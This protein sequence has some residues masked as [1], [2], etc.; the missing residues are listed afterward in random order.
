MAKD[1]TKLFNELKEELKKEVRTLKDSFDR[2]IRADLRDVKTGMDFMNSHFEQ[3]KRKIDDVLRENMNLKSQNDSLR[4]TNEAMQKDMK[5]C[6]TR[7]LLCEQYTRNVNLEIKGLAKRDN[8]DL[9]AVLTQI[10]GLI[11]EPIAHADVEV[12][13]RVPTRIA[14]ESNI[15]IQFVSRR[16]RDAVLEKAKRRRITSGDLGVSPTVPVFVNEHLCPALKRLLGQAI[17]RKH[18]FHWKF[19][20]VTNGKI[21]AKKTDSAPSIQIVNEDDLAKIC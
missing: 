1:L 4:Q 7:L 2:D 14:G 5:Q 15:I 21:F 11:G 9:E 8:E 16:K 12:C 17:G 20:W 6:Q 18:E 13:H 3:M 10:G 19:V